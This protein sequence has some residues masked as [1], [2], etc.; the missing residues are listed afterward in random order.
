MYN[1][2]TRDASYI[3]FIAPISMPV[4]L[5]SDQRKEKDSVIKWYKSWKNNVEIHIKKLQLQLRNTKW[6]QFKERHT[7]KFWI[8][9]SVQRAESLSLNIE[10]V[11]NKE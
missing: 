1:S 5:M 11:M 4:P 2:L 7:I 8:K 3:R 9:H 10:R 6:Y